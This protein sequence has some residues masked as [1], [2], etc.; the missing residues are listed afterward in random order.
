[1]PVVEEPKRE[2]KVKGEADDDEDETPDKYNRLD[3]LIKLFL[4]LTIIL[5]KE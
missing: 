1:M 5:W 4:L 2:I 3:S